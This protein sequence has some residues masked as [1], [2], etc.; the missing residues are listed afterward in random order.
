MDEEVRDRV[1]NLLVLHVGVVREKLTP[2]TTLAGDLG[3]ELDVAE[4]FFA[5]FSKEFGVPLVPAD[6]EGYLTTDAVGI[7]TAIVV[8]GPTLLLAWLLNKIAASIPFW[9]D[10]VIGL[11]CTLTALY[12]WRKYRPLPRIS[13]QDLIDSANAREWKV[14]R[15]MPEPNSSTPAKPNS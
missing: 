10:S 13:I 15:Y 6:W 3:M 9:F 1:F 12:L 11:A 5:D 2:E 4:G 7:G 14:G 8:F